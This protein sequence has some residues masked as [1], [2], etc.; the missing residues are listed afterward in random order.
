MTMTQIIGV[1]D[2]EWNFYERLYT[3]DFYIEA[4]NEHSIN[5]QQNLYNR[6]LLVW[7]SI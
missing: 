3:N 1:V 6:H 4:K 7:I 5:Y 2:L